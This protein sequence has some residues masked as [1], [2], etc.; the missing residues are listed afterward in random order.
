ML[1][2]TRDEAESEKTILSR[3]E[4]RFNLKPNWLAA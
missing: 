1:A 4:Q 3:V 2:Q